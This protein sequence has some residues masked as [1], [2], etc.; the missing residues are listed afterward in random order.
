MKNLL[1]LALGVL[2]LIAITILFGVLQNETADTTNGESNDLT[3]RYINGKFKPSKMT[4]SVGDTVTFSNETGNVFWPAS[5]LHPTHTVYPGSNISK[6]DTDKAGTLFDACEGIG[7]DLE[8]QFQ[9]DEVGTWGYHDH[10]RPSNTGKII[11]R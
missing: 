1:Y 3:V 2:L 8:W 6:C 10:L 7:T 11:V 9:F 5:G 4:V